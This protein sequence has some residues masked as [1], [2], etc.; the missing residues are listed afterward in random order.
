[1]LATARQMLGGSF[2]G[3]EGGTPGGELNDVFKT[4]SG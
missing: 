1:M 3:L 4:F 2:E